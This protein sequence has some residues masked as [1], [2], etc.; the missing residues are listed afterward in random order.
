MPSNISVCRNGECRVYGYPV[1]I[2]PGAD[3]GEIDVTLIDTCTSL[4]DFCRAKDILV[5]ALVDWLSNEGES[6][7]G[8]MP[9]RDTYCIGQTNA[10]LACISGEKKITYTNPSGVVPADA[11]TV[12]V[13]LP[14][15]CDNIFA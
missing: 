11:Q 14:M 3:A 2:Q 13:S 5:R 9:C 6:T 7:E 12:V 15:T 8:L 4:N 10:G 1:T